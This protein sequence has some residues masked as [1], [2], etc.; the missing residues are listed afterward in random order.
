MSRVIM[1]GVVRGGVRGGSGRS[2]TP[3]VLMVDSYP[4][5]GGMGMLWWRVLM[6][7]R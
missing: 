2:H 7:G 1:G 4:F 6:G 5:C 3:E